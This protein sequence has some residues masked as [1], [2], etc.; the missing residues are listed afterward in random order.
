MSNDG[1]AGAANV[2]SH[3]D[4]CAIH[5]GLATLTAQLLNHLND[6]IDPRRAD[7]MT[8]RLQ[9]SARA[10]RHAS[11]WADLVIE[12]ES[13]SLPAFGESTCFQ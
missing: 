9:A 11:I 3:A 10:H 12:A 7:R 1:R 13:N 8:P 2:L 4:F 6:L 5:L